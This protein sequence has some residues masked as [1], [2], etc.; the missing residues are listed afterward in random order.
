[1]PPGASRCFPLSFTNTP[2]SLVWIPGH[3][4]P[5]FRTPQVP[6][7]HTHTRSPPPFS[8]PEDGGSTRSRSHFSASQNVGP[9]TARPAVP[10]AAD[11]PPR[12]RA[13]AQPHPLTLVTE[14]APQFGE[15]QPHHGHLGRPR[16]P[17]AAGAAARGPSAARAGSARGKRPGRRREATGWP[18]S[19]DR[20]LGCRSEGAAPS[21]VRRV[22]CFEPSE[23][24]ADP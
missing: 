1:M 14:E 19:V 20:P 5:P 24:N 22:L 23:P 8:Q 18:G 3:Q 2:K 4:T 7:A 6:R 13:V 21:P 10:P 11:A 15:E 16:G 17:S 9:P 12:A